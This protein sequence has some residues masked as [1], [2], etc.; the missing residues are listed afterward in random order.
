M[1]SFVH[2]LLL[3]ACGNT[4]EIPDRY[5]QNWVKANMRTLLITVALTLALL[6][7]AYGALL[8]SRSTSFQLFGETIPSITTERPFV[9]LTLDDGPSPKHL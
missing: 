1:F 7:L 9:A 4:A 2:G 3:F 8:I 6:L 5:A